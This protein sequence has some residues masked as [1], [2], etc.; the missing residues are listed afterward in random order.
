MNVYLGV[1]VREGWHVSN[2]T[3]QVGSS[4]WKSIILAV[5]PSRIAGNRKSSSHATIV[6]LSDCGTDI[7]ITVLRQMLH[8]HHG[9]FCT[10]V[11]PDTTF[12]KLHPTCNQTL[13]APG[14]LGVHPVGFRGS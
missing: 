10:R 3:S 1:D 4:Y 6:D 7:G 11:R 13:T 8:R 12:E 2:H 5:A 14:Q 9:D